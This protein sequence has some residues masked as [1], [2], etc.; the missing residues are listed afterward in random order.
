MG[1]PESTTTRSGV[2]FIISLNG[3]MLCNICDYLI[4]LKAMD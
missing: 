3:N 2:D 1:G 4:G